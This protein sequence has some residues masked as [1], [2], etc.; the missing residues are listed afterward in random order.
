MFLPYAVKARVFYPVSSNTE[1]ILS[2]VGILW[3]F[4]TQYAINKDYFK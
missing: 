4:A 1:E 3:N 2:P